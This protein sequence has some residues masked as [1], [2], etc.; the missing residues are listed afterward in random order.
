MVAER[1]W[2]LPRSNSVRANQ[3]RYGA[4]RENGAF[5]L[6]CRIVGISEKTL[7]LGRRVKAPSRL[8]ARRAT[9]GLQIAPRG[10]SHG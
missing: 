7:T 10:P 6:F 8:V 3:T 9:R 2:C 1:T 5:A 4:P